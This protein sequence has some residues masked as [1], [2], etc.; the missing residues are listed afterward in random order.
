MSLRHQSEKPRLNGMVK[1]SRC[2]QENPD[3]F[4][5]CGACGADLDADTLA[6]ETR[7]TVTVV[8]SDV[9]GSTALGETLDP[10]SLRR[11]MG[12][13][14]DEMKAV[15]E[16]HEGTVEKFI[17]DAV[18]AVFGIP[19]VHEDDALRA[20]R[21]AAEMRERL[22]GLNEGLERDWGI[23]IAARTGVNT[24]EVVAG[25]ASGGQRFATGDAVNVAK[26][27]EEAALAGEILLG[28]TTYRLVR[29]AVEV[30]PVDELE[31]KGKGSPVKAYRLLSIEPGAEGRAR[32]LDSP[33]VGRERERSLLEQAY[34]RAV[35]DGACHLITVLGTAG[36]GKSRLIAEFV[37]S[38]GE[39]ATVV[40]GRC[41]PYGEG[42]TFRPLS[43]VVRHLY[44]ENLGEITVRLAG[45]ENAELI[46]ARVAAAVGLA[47]GASPSEETFWATRKLF[48]AHAQER[49]LVVVF[50]DVQWGE[51]TFLDLVE[52]IADLSRDAPI[53]LVC[54]ARPELLDARPGW[55]G[56]KFNA[57]SVLLEPLSEDD[58]AQLIDNLL[59]R[60]E[61]EANVRARV[62]EAAEGNPLFVEE[63]LGML[64][65][66]DLLERQNGS[67]TAT[68]DLSSVSVPPTIQA[69]LSARLDRLAPAERSVVERASVEGKVFHQGA[70]AELLP[71]E[72]RSDVGGHL[73]MLVRKELLRPDRA[74][75]AGEDAF[76]FRH[77]L[78]RDA[79]YDAMPKELRAELHQR[80]AA[81][82]ERAAADR[83]SEY[84]EI[85]GFHLEQAYRFRVE[86][87]PPDNETR[88]LGARASERLSSASGR[89]LAR[90]DAPAAI[91]LL[92][93]AVEVL[94]ADSPDLPKLLCDLGHALSDRGEFA[95]AKAVLSDAKTAAEARDETA[96]AAIALL[97]STWLQLLAGGGSVEEAKTKIE[98]SALALERLGHEG[99]LAE[100]Y[101]FLGTMLMWT[102][103]CGDATGTLQR[104]V[105]L[106]RQAGDDKIAS[107]S[108]SWLLNNAIWGPMA[109]ED[110]LLLCERVARE[111]RS[112]QLQGSA[113]ISQ[114]VLLAM[115]G[116]WEESRAQIHTGRKLLEELGQHVTLA[117]T[118]MAVAR[119]ELFVGDVAKSEE[120]LRLGYE[121]LEQMGEKAYLSTVAALLA[122]AL[123]GQERYDEAERYAGEARRL[124]AKDDLTTQMYWRVAQAEVLASRGQVEEA[125]RLVQE[126]QDV[127]DPTDY[128]TDRAAALLS[129]ATVENAAGS[130]DRARVALEQAV[131]LF[132]E[133]G[134]VTA[135]AHTRELIA[136][137]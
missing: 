112:R 74:E 89:A 14:F 103:R 65:D 69:L 93:R 22:A 67:W 79:T 122:A 119:A 2:G 120:E 132:E 109:V 38:L 34:E 107:R 5:F 125:F 92:D 47:E 110:G 116:R 82:L 18:M 131:G 48:E 105:T 87:A 29:D 39:R 99:G 66:D 135:A 33:M 30:E 133:K 20:A 58:S 6:R 72:I 115:A 7:K 106:A 55:G 75:F 27:F 40:G 95:R 64:I 96:L 97:R 36:V 26:R 90:G 59:G 24:G 113:S 16:S 73:Q 102:G 1:C 50:D 60:A 129:R 123:C 121:V 51:A 94:P 42:I 76:R 43:E 111:A 62:T 71:A 44:G 98:E 53:L 35:G 84:E 56:G 85:L 78:I 63:M 10:E 28:E 128:T 8:F 61:L 104:S 41:L 45:D 77:L 17:G 23:R 25:D 57:T 118:R 100:A 31:L 52:H 32:R 11:V 86:L 70:V 3:G 130:R 81:W 91:S 49:P 21:A 4:K 101:S 88:S 127:I 37:D 54:L 9:T 12:R 134:D 83:V 126:A 124:G 15:V 114:G 108:L 46:A 13:Y 136:A 137:M 19:V 117:A 68:G 80:F